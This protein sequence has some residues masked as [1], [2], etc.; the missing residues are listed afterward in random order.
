MKSVAIFA[1]IGLLLTT[2]L[3]NTYKPRA[4]NRNFVVHVAS[5]ES[6]KTHASK[7]NVNYFQQ[8]IIL[9][10]TTQDLTSNLAISKFGIHTYPRTW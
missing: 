3:L 4:N 8:S 10:E 5:I 7:S 6:G 2:L 1:Y 9:L